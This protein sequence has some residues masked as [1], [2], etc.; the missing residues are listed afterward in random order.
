L[1]IGIEQGTQKPEVATKVAEHLDIED[2]KIRALARS[3]G[4]AVLAMS[5]HTF[6]KLCKYA[7]QPALNHG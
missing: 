5:L 4:E 3:Q 2:L 6:F 7:Y 1:T